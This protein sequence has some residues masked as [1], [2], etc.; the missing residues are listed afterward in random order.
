MTKAS[1][2][3]CFRRRK[4]VKNFSLLVVAVLAG[5]S[6]AS[7]SPLLPAAPGGAPAVP[8]SPMSESSDGNTCTRQTGQNTPRLNGSIARPPIG[9]C[10]EPPPAGKQTPAPVGYLYVTNKTASGESQLVVYRGLTSSA[11]YRMI[12]K[13]VHDVGGMTVGHDG[14]VFVANGT[15]GNVLEFAPGASSIVR[16]YSKGLSNPVDVAVTDNRL[17]VTDRGTAADGYAQQI[18]E[19]ST[20]T[21]QVS[22]VSAVGGLGA[23][24]THNAGVAVNATSPATFFVSANS[25]NQPPLADRD[26]TG[27]TYTFAQNLFPTLW[28]N[29]ALDHNTQV[30]GV[31]FD[32]R[33]RLY[34]ADPCANAVVVYEYKHY[35]WIYIRTIA[36]PVKMP[37]YLTVG[38]GY[39]AI[40]STG[41]AAN[42]S[43]YV[44]LV[45]IRNPAIVTTF[46]SGLTH[47]IGAGVGPP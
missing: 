40:P 38:N 47:P 13:S 31:A 14:H 2:F 10:H 15:Q 46:N 37:M 7:Q 3:L 1:A 9:T 39:L 26:C 36:V 43:G 6:A 28:E 42:D 19:F 25:L 21:G 29:V 35:S 33:D 22:S 16:T 8:A 11:P 18:V 23:G 27:S 44:T 24:A 34:A 30:S 32:A 5:C 41:S 20:T 4:L 12:V 45:D 17:Y